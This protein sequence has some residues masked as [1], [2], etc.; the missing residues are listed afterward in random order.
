MKFI[1]IVKN[2]VQKHGFSALKVSV[3]FMRAVYQLAIHTHQKMSTFVPGLPSKLGNINFN[4]EHTH[5]YTLY[6]QLKTVNVY[7]FYAVTLTLW[8]GRRGLK[9]YVTM[10]LWLPQIVGQAPLCA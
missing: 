10:T 7:N 1:Y 8:S 3:G 9:L 4:V 2:H 6:Y 5:T